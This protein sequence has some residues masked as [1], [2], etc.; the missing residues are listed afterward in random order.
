MSKSD[1]DAKKCRSCSLGTPGAS[2]LDDGVERCRF[3]SSANEVIWSRATLMVNRKVEAG[4]E[5]ESWG[6]WA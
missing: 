2:S 3:A 5:E 4:L 6:D 1:P